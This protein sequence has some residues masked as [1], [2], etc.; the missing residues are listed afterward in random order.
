MFTEQVFCQSEVNV[1]AYLPP[2]GDD[3]WQRLVF[4]IARSKWPMNKILRLK[5]A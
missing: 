1:R 2:V 3:D 5:M 4:T